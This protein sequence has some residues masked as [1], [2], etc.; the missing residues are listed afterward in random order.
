M[1]FVFGPK[2]GKLMIFAT[3]KILI[4]I[5]FLFLF[6]V[7]VGLSFSLKVY[8]KLQIGN[9]NNAFKVVIITNLEQKQKSA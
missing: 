2:F 6:S 9:S 3:A 7:L 4:L 1:K 8:F 5:T